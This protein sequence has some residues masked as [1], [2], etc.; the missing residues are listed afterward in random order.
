M[1]SARTWE[2]A[3]RWS[4]IC[5]TALA[6]PAHAARQSR[7]PVPARAPVLAQDSA[8]APALPAPVVSAIAAVNQKVIRDRLWHLLAKVA[9]TGG[10]TVHDRL[11]LRQALITA[12]PAEQQ[13]PA[14]WRAYAAAELALGQPGMALRWFAVGWRRGTGDW[15]WLLDWAELLRRSGRPNGARRI[16][17]F[18]RRHIEPGKLRE[19]QKAL[20][21]QEGLIERLRGVEQA[22]NGAPAAAA[23]SRPAKTDEDDS[24]DEAEDSGDDDS[25]DDGDE[26][27]GADATPIAPSAASRESAAAP[28][29]SSADPEDETEE[30]DST[31]VFA[32]TA[33]TEAH[34]LG[35]LIVA[36]AQARGDLSWHQLGVSVRMGYAHL[37]ESDP[38]FALDKLGLQRGEFDLAALAKWRFARGKIEVGAGGNLR[39]AGYSVAYGTLHG[40]YDLGHGVSGELN[41]GLNQIVDDTSRLRLLG[42]RDRVGGGLYFDLTPRE[43]INAVADWHRYQ[44]R[45]RER[46]SDGYATYLELGHRLRLANP[47]LSVR[48]SAFWEENRLVQA[49]PPDLLRRLGLPQSASADD[50]LD[51]VTFVVPMF[52]M[53]GA[54]LTVRRGVPGVA[55]VD[56]HRVRCFADLWLGYLWPVSSVGFDLQLGLGL[57]TP[58]LGELSILSFLSNSRQG[59][60]SEGFSWGFGL[61]YVH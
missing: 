5:A 16:L 43:F 61:R 40:D 39:A 10:G 33:G 25:D 15:L 58:Q 7:A 46:L 21:S 47:G 19:A 29:T 42:T 48:L 53:V 20:A 13:D 38:T 22:A 32:P 34:G 26:D 44:T 1:G 23:K 17:G 59:G 35:S 14:L 31:R 60:G 27:E 6:L 11:R 41:V 30:P 57:S 49:L 2:W 9:V 4:L 36:S 50:E 51:V 55:P 18:A 52:A 37:S 54:G 12:R 45:G 56:D 3:K 8:S 24:E 28:S